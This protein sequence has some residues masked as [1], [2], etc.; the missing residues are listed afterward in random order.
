MKWDKVKNKKT[1]FDQIQIGVKKIRTEIV[2]RNIN[3]WNNRI[4]RMLQ[5]KLRICFLNEIHDLKEWKILYRM[6]LER[7]LH[8]IGNYPKEGKTF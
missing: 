3:S 6:N 4:Y 5:E 7:S 2:R 8:Y 1:L